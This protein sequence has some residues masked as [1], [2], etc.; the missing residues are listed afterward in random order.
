MREILAVNLRFRCHFQTKN[1]IALYNMQFRLEC[2]QNIMWCFLRRSKAA[3]LVI[4]ARMYGV[5]KLISIF[6]IFLFFNTFDSTR[7]LDSSV[8]VFLSGC[9][10]SDGISIDEENSL[11]FIRVI[12]CVTDKRPVAH[13]GTRGQ[14]GC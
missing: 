7:L 6:I 10:L 4:L 1:H 12:T 3:R 9:V 8:F 11:L 14:Q 13:C 5:R 2:N